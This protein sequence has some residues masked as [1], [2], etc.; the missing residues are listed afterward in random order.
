M[1]L[2]FIKINCQKYKYIKFQLEKILL[3]EIIR[4]IKKTVYKFTKAGY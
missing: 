3:N 4:N 2:L 1:F